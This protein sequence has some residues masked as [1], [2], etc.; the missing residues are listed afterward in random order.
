MQKQFLLAYQ[1]T[2]RKERKKST[3]SGLKIE[4]D[5]RIKSISRL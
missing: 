3:T 5:H 2:R 1:E 4:L